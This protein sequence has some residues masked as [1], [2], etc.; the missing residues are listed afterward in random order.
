ME[1]T[2]N[3]AKTLGTNRHAV[4]GSCTRAFKNSPIGL[5]HKLPVLTLWCQVRY[6]S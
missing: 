2:F 4:P 3:M 6:Q 1:L 5:I